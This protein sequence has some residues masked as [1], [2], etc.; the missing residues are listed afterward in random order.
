MVL[1]RLRIGSEEK[2]RREALRGAGVHRGAYRMFND[3]IS[4]VRSLLDEATS[5]MRGGNNATA[6]VII[7]QALAE[8]P[9]KRM[10]E[11]AAIEHPVIMFLRHG[12]SYTHLQHLYPVRSSEV[13]LRKAI[14]K[15]RAVLKDWLRH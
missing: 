1:T 6:L 8:V 9:T 4:E 11:L 15:E 3:S 7:D 13:R 2:L 10:V 14:N 5:A 12:V